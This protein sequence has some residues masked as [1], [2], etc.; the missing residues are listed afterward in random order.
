MI[1]QQLVQVIIV[2][3]VREQVTWDP[4]SQVQVL[5]V[6]SYDVNLNG[7]KMQ[8]AMMSSRRRETLMY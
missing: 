2:Y 7:Y 8:K 4:S 6:K 1:M 5:N 3:Q